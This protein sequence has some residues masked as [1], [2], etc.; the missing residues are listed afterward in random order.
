MVARPLPDLLLLFA[1]AAP[2]TNTSL[3]VSPGEEVLE[4][5]T[6][7]LTCRSDAL[8]PATLVLW[9]E[10][11]EL[12][13]TELASVPELSFSLSSALMEDSAHYQCEASNQYGSQRDT[14]PVSVRG[15]SSL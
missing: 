2:P 15:S 14:R 11:V 9:R 12:Q 7:T 1:S 3:S 6:V 13:R 10:G 8:P 5:Q 4:G